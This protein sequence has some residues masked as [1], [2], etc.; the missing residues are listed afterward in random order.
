MLKGIYYPILIRPSFV[1]HAAGKN[2]LRHK[3]HMYVVVKAITYR[4]LGWLRTK[5]SEFATL[6]QNSDFSLQV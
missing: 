1:W 6:R 5:K 3:S 4:K 2:P